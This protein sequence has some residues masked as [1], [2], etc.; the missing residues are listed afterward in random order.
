M[1]E[2]QFIQLLHR[3]EKGLCTPE[4][5]ARLEQWLDNMK[6]GDSPFKSATEKAR[7]KMA[8]HDSVYTKAG[9]P[10][11]KG[12]TLTS[13]WMKVAATLLILVSA[14][15]ALIKFDLVEFG[16][17]NVAIETEAKNAIQ[18]ILLPDGSI[19]WLKPHSKL[20][21]PEIFEGNER[22]VSLAGEALF[23]IAKDPEHPFIIHSGD[24]T[25]RVL[26]TSFNI[27]N[28]FEHTEI[29]VL[30][31]RVSVTLAKTNEQIELLPSERIMYAH[32]TRQLQKEEEVVK[33]KPPV[34]ECIKGTE[35]N[36]FFQD[37]RVSDIAS[38]IED[39]FN[40]T[41]TVTGKIE[42]CVI[43]ADFTDQSLNNT[44]DMIS[45]ALNAAYEI[46]EG[47]VTLKG[48]GCR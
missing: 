3:F 32:A 36:M 35:Y 11:G 40:V 45:E 46:E 14:S 21:Y 7:I 22:I 9:I 19:I 24:L 38:R 31:G 8:L 30:T 37:T 39:K 18:K 12:R 5:Q 1:T 26:G 13:F 4:E 43:T 44:L 34:E 17:Q 27:K 48:D 6:E 33:N 47:K 15:Y 28:T 42:S 29:Y 2:H 25:T 41:V 16:R 23:E 10:R 20:T